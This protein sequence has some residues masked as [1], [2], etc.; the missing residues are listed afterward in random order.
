MMTLRYE[1]SMS[2]EAILLKY[3]KNTNKEQYLS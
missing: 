1:S 3:I 2:I